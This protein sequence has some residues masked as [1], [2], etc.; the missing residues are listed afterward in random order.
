VGSDYREVTFTSRIDQLQLSGWLFR[1]PQATGRSVVFAHGWNQNRADVPYGAADLT[2]DLLRHGYDVLLFDFRATG[3]S[4]GGRY[5]L[6]N[7]ERRDVLGAYDFMRAQGYR[8]GRMAFIAV[9]LGAAAALEAAPQM[10][11]AGAI[12]IDSSF[13]EL[14]PMIYKLYDQYSRGFP[15][16]FIPGIIAA[17]RLF[18]SFDPDLRP[19]DSVR[20]LPTRAF[21]FIHGS[22]D[23]F[24]PLT[25]SREL[26]A[27]SSNPASRLVIFPGS[28]HVQSFHDHRTDYLAAIYG[29]LDSQLEPA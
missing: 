27:A 18:F 20:A 26:Y 29:F 16:F 15:R 10:S 1:S 25:T 8:A 23:E 24:T 5:T 14:R 9:S 21:L 12:V 7:L 6:G 19:L 4:A 11:E 3:R 13:A 17:G 2:G 22:E 28:G